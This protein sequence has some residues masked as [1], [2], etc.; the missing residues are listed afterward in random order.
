MYVGKEK[1]AELGPGEVIGEVALRQKKLRTATVSTL[2]AAELLH[3]ERDDLDRQL[4]QI[5]ALGKAIDATV[6]RHMGEPTAEQ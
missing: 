4:R 5:P 1:V 2:E 3:I 6:S